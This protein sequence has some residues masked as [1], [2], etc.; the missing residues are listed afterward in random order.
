MEQKN[1]NLRKTTIGQGRNYTSVCLL[2]YPYFK[3]NH[4]TIIVHMSDHLTSSL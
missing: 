3:E 1:V 4:E 2:N